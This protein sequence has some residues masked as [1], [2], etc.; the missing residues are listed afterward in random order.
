MRDFSHLLAY[1][2]RLRGCQ[3]ITDRC[4]LS[5]LLSQVTCPGQLVLFSLVS[6][7]HQD[8]PQHNAEQPES[9]TNQPADDRHPGYPTNNNPSKSKDTEDDD[10]LQSMETYELIVLFQQEKHEATYPPQNI[11]Q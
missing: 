11:A 4:S 9:R 1:C 3:T 8:Y 6:F 5:I 10:R 2:D 7:N